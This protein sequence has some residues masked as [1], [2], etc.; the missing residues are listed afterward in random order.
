VLA[1]VLEIVWKEIFYLRMKYQENRNGEF[2][3]VTIE[4]VMHPGG[5]G[6]VVPGDTCLAHPGKKGRQIQRR[7]SAAS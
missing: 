1:F 6:K 2:C 4:G 5:A 7:T 3:I